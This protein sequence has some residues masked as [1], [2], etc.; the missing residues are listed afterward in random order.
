M[1]LMIGCVTQATCNWSNPLVAANSSVDAGIRL[2][3]QDYFGILQRQSARR[4][5]PASVEVQDS[6]VSEKRLLDWNVMGTYTLLNLEGAAPFNL[7]ADT[8][9]LLL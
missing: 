7:S 2:R 6:T 4:P 1:R 8:R 9:L 5:I 3:S